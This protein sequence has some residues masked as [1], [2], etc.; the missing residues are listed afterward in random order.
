LEKEKIDCTKEQ[1]RI[2]AEGHITTEALMW[3]QNT[4]QKT[5]SGM[6]IIYLE[7]VFLEKVISVER[8]TVEID[9]I[10]NITN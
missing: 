7:N 2:A 6:V 4:N 1:M 8:R 10:S 3:N 5:I 9:P